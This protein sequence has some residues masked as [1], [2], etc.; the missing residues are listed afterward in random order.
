MAAIEETL[1]ARSL[2]TLLEA[3]DDD[4]GESLDD[5]SSVAIDEPS[6][7]TTPFSV[8]SSEEHDEL[9]RRRSDWVRTM[10]LFNYDFCFLSTEARE[11]SSPHLALSCSPPPPPLRRT[12]SFEG[13][14]MIAALDGCDAKATPPPSIM[15]SASATSSPLTSPRPRNASFAVDSMR[16][17][18]YFPPPAAFGEQPSA[19]EQRA[20]VAI[21]PFPASSDQDTTST[22]APAHLPPG[23]GDARQRGSPQRVSFAHPQPVGASNAALPRLL[24]RDAAAIVRAAPSS[25]GSHTTTALQIRGAQ[26]HGAHEGHDDHQH[27]SHHVAFL[28]HGRRKSAFERFST[29]KESK[30][31][32]SSPTKESSLDSFFERRRNTIVSSA[33]GEPH[34]A[35]PSDALRVRP[36]S[37]VS[38]STAAVAVTT[39]TATQSKAAFPALEGGGGGGGRGEEGS[40]PYGDRQWLWISPRTRDGEYSEMPSAGSTLATIGEN[41]LIMPL[42]SRHF[43]AMRSCEPIRRPQ[44]TESWMLPSS[45]QRS[46][47][48][49]F[50]HQPPRS[51]MDGSDGYASLPSLAEHFASLPERGAVVFGEG[52]SATTALGRASSRDAPSVATLK[53]SSMSLGVFDSIL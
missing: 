40:N 14:R 4:G 53:R 46:E 43:A 1:E 52:G 11:G 50:F 19:Y 49:D 31:G 34:T 12:A 39:T 24:E 42:A 22:G 13:S 15:L 25:S 26:G 2:F 51:P 27:G 37:G 6:R 28:S 44:S 48:H 7:E 33:G 47:S 21:A 16:T 10:P 36:R 18:R 41:T 38:Q 9:N 17:S 45:R 5:A 8:A 29:R 30:S 23:F 32:G 20:A 35:A 3:A